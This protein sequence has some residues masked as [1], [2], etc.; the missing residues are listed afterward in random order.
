VLN[1]YEKRT[2]HGGSLLNG[3]PWIGPN[4]NIYGGAPTIAATDFFSDFKKPLEPSV[5]TSITQGSP[6]LDE[7]IIKFNDELKKDK[8]TKR[9]FLL[10]PLKASVPAHVSAS[11][12]PQKASDYKFLQI[13]PY[14]GFQLSWS[15][16]PNER[17]RF[18]PTRGYPSD[19]AYG[20]T[21]LSY[22]P[23]QGKLEL[24]ALAS[25]THQNP[26][27]YSSNNPFLLK[28]AEK[29]NQAFRREA[30]EILEVT[31]QP[32]FTVKTA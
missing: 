18:Y 11:Q 26:Q 29:L 32:D 20:W 19:P 1:A 21:T 28:K 8:T 12:V 25:M 9:S 2:R 22:K 31:E 4:G 6:S 3:T 24:G 16:D 7:A 10:F 5:V 15:Y 14:D 13:N 17:S 27:R 30:A 23:S